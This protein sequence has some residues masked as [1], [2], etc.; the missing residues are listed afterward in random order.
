MASFL[1]KHRGFKLSSSGL[2]SLPTVSTLNLYVSN[3]PY[4]TPCYHRWQARR[5]AFWIILKSAAERQ[6]LW[7]EHF[8]GGN[9]REF[10]R[11]SRAGMET[12][13]MSPYLGFGNPRCRLAP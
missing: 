3:S 6:K 9:P 12:S 5:K 11:G 4:L 8:D 2:D 7:M 13:C 10:L 1:H